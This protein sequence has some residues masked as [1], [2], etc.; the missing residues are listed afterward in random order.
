MAVNT[1]Y[2]GVYINQVPSDH[3]INSAATAV[4]A[5]I[6]YAEKGITNKAVRVQSFQDYENE[7]GGLSANSPMSYVIYMFFENGG[8]DSWV[9][10]VPPSDGNEITGDDV[11]DCLSAIDEIKGQFNLMCIPPSGTVSDLKDLLWVGDTPSYLLTAALQYCEDNNVFLI[12]D[13][14]VNWASPEEASKAQL[15]TYNSHGAIYYPMVKILDPL[16]QTDTIDF[17][18]CGAVA[19]VYATNDAQ[20][21]VWHAPAG[22]NT[23]LIGMAGLAYKMTDNDTGLLNPLGINSLMRFQ[24]YGDLVWGARTLKGADALSDEYKYINIRRLV[25]YIE[26]SL[27]Q[28]LGWVVFEQNNQKLWGDVKKTITEF[29]TSL[30]QQGAFFGNNASEAFFVTC[31]A[32][33]NPPET[34]VKGKLFI[35]IGVAPVHPAEFIII[36]IQQA[37]TAK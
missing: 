30:W 14:S 12:V 34:I 18:P 24:T 22:T 2:P 10:N 17:V 9:V 15:P 29:L 19:G 16:N 8:S 13:P 31:D 20:Y 37:T 36:R 23:P 1:T 27:Q 6:G 26:L 25:T 28:S 4:T 32:S 3:P 7:F 11:H 33:N 5:F 35:D 21:G